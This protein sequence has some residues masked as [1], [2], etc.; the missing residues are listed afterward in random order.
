MDIKKMA[1]FF[2][3]VPPGGRERLR[4]SRRNHATLRTAI[5]A[6]RGIVRE[7]TGGNYR[8]IYAYTVYLDL[9]NEGTEPIAS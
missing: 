6:L 4:A 5:A 7:L 3:S 1:F 9:L 8:R 2:I